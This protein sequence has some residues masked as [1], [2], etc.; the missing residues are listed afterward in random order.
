MAARFRTALK[1]IRFWWIAVLALPGILFFASPGEASA[2]WLLFGAALLLSLVGWSA[3]SRRGSGSLSAAFV[4]GL[5]LFLAGAGAVWVV[6]VGLRGAMI[7][8]LFSCGAALYALFFLARYSAPGVR[9]VVN[10]LWLAPLLLLTGAAGGAALFGFFASLWSRTMLELPETPLLFFGAAVLL[11]GVGILRFC[12][13]PFSPRRFAAIAGAAA[14]AGVLLWCCAALWGYLH[15]GMV[16][17]P[18]EAAARPAPEIAANRDGYAAWSELYRKLLLHQEASP[19]FWERLF[20]I[21]RRGDDALEKELDSPLLAPLPEA[22]DAL[23]GLDWRIPPDVALGGKDSDPLIRGLRDFAGLCAARAGRAARNGDW[24]LFFRELNRGIAVAEPFSRQHLLV[25]GLLADLAR[26]QLVRE[27]VELGPA[28]PEY[29][30]EYRKLLEAVR[31][32]DPLD[33]A[34]EYEL[35]LLTA[36]AA[37]Q[38]RLPRFATLLGRRGFL[39]SWSGTPA[40]QWLLLPYRLNRAAARLD[41]FAAVQRQLRALAALPMMPEELRSLE[42]ANATGEMLKMFGTAVFRLRASKLFDETG[43]ALKLFRSEYGRYPETLAELTPSP[44]PAAG[45]DPVTG[46]PFEYSRAE[47]GFLLSAD[48][49]DADSPLTFL[50]ER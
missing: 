50:T 47:H 11:G 9:G 16:R 19:A 33:S 39:E 21:G 31:R 22:F 32:F 46:K 20:L 23:A 2:P 45:P 48:R 3:A 49:D 41:A 25:A 44:L 15:L 12:R 40:G 28:G 42:P 8:P 18:V 30:P 27:A 35:A 10:L 26:R 1:Q 6:N 17:F 5:L 4:S 34:D 24:P 14:A 36:D 43:L 29:V 13:P 7:F 37:A 38:N